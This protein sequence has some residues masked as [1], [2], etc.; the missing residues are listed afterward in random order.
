MRKYQLKNFVSF[1]FGVLLVIAL[2]VSGSLYLFYHPQ[3]SLPTER[4]TEPAPEPP[5]VVDPSLH[6]L[7][8]LPLPENASTTRPFAVMI[9]NA[10]EA[11][12]QYGLSKADIVYH[13]LVEG[14]VTRFMAVFS[15]QAAERIGPVR[16]ARPYF[17]RHAQDWDAIYV[18]SGGSATAL[19]VLQ[20]NPTRISGLNEFANG[21]FF[22]RSSAPAPHDLF[23]T[24]ALLKNA[25]EKRALSL[26]LST[27][28]SW[29]FST[30]SDPDASSAMSASIPF[31]L[32]RMS[33]TYHYNS[34]TNSYDRTQGTSAQYDNLDG[35]RISP[36]N[37]LLVFKR[38]AAIADPQKLGLIDFT[39]NGAGELVLCTNGKKIDGRWSRSADG[40]TV[41]SDAN[42]R[43]LLLS[44]GQTFI[45]ILPTEFKESIIMQ[46]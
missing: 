18:H 33:V 15:S 34:I 45:E 44:P 23:T 40:P 29:G 3:A 37:V 42:G 6:P 36:A 2:G 35:K 22:W 31:S 20:Q 32:P 5:P 30:G 17:I 9:D 14:G 21:P 28:P 41:Y 13:V 38:S 11:R 43:T 10:P 27:L 39:D 26:V 19:K 7:T 4:Q 8:G 46:E 16:S 12:P 1:S 25:A 24:S